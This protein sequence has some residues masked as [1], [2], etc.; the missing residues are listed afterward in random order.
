M[1]ITLLTIPLWQLCL[2]KIPEKYKEIMK[3]AEFMSI[4]FNKDLYPMVRYRVTK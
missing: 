2:N 3:T 4:G 1:K